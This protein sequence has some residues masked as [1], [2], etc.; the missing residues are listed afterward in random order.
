[1]IN[2]AHVVV[3]SRDAE[4]DRAFFRH[5]LGFPSVDAG[6]GWL[7]FG[8]PEAEAALHPAE[9]GH[10]H[11]LYLMC[12]DLRAEM[13]TLRA[14]GAEFAPVVEARWGLITKIRLPGGGEVGLYQPRHPRPTH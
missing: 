13:E 10:P 11:E 9:A 6:H 5:T 3:Y 7:I 14:R 2:G 1:M 4:A 8:L 12:D